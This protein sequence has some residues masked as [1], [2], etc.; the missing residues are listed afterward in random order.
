MSYV[1]NERDQQSLEWIGGSTVR[2]LLDS[3]TT[4]GQLTAI[5]SALNAGDAAPVHVHS[6]EDEVFLLVSGSAVVWSGDDRYEL[7]AGGV[8]YLPRDVPH[9]YRI[10]SDGTQ[11]LTLC[12]PGGIEGFFRGAGHDLATQRPDNWQLTPAVMAPHAQ[13]HGITLL[14]PPRRD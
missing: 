13:A 1:A 8:A 12:T 7:D 4:S 3:V 14:G 9:S 6:L 5:S 2:V 11:M 10:T